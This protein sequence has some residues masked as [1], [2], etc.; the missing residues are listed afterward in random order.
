[1]STKSSNPVQDIQEPTRIQPAVPMAPVTAQPQA[2]GP[3]IVVNVQNSMNANGLN[4]GENAIN[5][6]PYVP[7]PWRTGIFHCCSD[8]EVCL[9][10]ALCPFLLPCYVASL[11]NE[12]CWLGC[13]PGAMFALRTGI[14]ERYRITG[15]VMKDYYAVCCCSLCSFCQMAREIKCQK[16]EPSRFFKPRYDYHGPFRPQ[17]SNWG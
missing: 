9:F 13:L 7:N 3:N 11:Y 15:T 12:S 4:R 16:R 14:R 2:A 8:F 6:I 10:G 5:E 1:M 17:P